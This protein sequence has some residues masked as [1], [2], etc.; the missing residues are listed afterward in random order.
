MSAEALLDT[1]VLS[2]VL[3]RRQPALARADAYLRNH[4]VL[5][6]S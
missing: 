2:A 4:G 3:R 5:T 1:D 6:F